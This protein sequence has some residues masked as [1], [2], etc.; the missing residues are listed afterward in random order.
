MHIIIIFE[1]ALILFVISGTTRIQV[2]R[3]E[4]KTLEPYFHINNYKKYLISL[5]YIFYLS[6]ILFTKSF[7]SNHEFRLKNVHN[8]RHDKQRRYR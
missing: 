3:V 6:N 8:R 2:K 4:I 7:F 1:K 5:Y